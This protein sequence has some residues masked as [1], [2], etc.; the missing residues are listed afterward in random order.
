MIFSHEGG[1]I[2]ALTNFHGR[3][4]TK[5]ELVGLLG[6]PHTKREL[7][8]N[9]LPS[10]RLSSPRVTNT[11]LQILVLG[12]AQVWKCSQVLSSNQSL[13]PTTR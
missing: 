9:S 12:P 11:S 7:K 1:K 13:N 3:P 10:R 5:R 4:H 2:A 6:S 8:D